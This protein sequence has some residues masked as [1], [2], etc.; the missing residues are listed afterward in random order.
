MWDAGILFLA[1]IAGNVSNIF[2]FSFELFREANSGE[3][4]EGWK[5]ENTDTKKTE[6]LSSS[7]AIRKTCR[8]I[9]RQENKYHAVYIVLLRPTLY[10]AKYPNVN[11]KNKFNASLLH[12]AG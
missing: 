1:T 8:E 7:V 4:L 11:K 9:G 2:F 5:A 6:A 12:Y 10:L 3:K